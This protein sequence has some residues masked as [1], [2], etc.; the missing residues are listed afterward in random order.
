MTPR[1]VSSN[2]SNGSGLGLIL[3]CCLVST[4]SGQPNHP[5]EIGYPYI[6]NFSS[7]DFNNAPEATWGTIKDERGI[8]Y[9]GNQAGVLEYDGAHWH[10]ITTPKKTYVRTFAKDPRNGR[11]YV[12]SSGDFGYL[13]PD[14]NGQ[15]QFVS[16]LDKVQESNRDFTDIWST[17]WTK[18][19]VYFLAH[20][21]LFRYTDA[22]GKIFAFERPKSRLVFANE[23]RGQVWVHDATVGFERISGDNLVPIP[24]SRRFAD[25]RRVI[26]MP[27]GADKILIADRGPDNPKVKFNSPLTL[28]DG[29]KFEPFPS[30]ADAFL[31]AHR[32]TI[33]QALDDGRFALGTTGVGLVILDHDGRMRWQIGQETGLIDDSV[34]GIYPDG[35]RLW[36]NVSKGLSRVDLP[37]PLS[38]FGPQSGIEGTKESI[39]RYLRS[40]YVGT[41]AGVYR[42]DSGGEG[43]AHFV[44]IPGTENLQ[45]PD[46][47]S[48]SDGVKDRLI[49]G[50][51]SGLFEIAAGKIQP[52][53]FHTGARPFAVT[54][55][56]VSKRDPRR[57]FVGL[58]DGL[59]SVRFDGHG[60]KDEG[61]FVKIPIE[62]V[63][64]IVEEP[65]GR[66]WLSAE[67]NGVQSFDSAKTGTDGVPIRNAPVE[68]Y[69]LKGTGD[70]GD[71]VFDL[72][73]RLLFTS[74][75][76]AHR[77]RLDDANRGFSELTK[78]DPFA[79]ALADP[80]EKAPNLQEDSK[81]DIWTYRG[82]N[83]FLLSK[84]GEQYEFMKQSV[85]A[86]FGSVSAVLREADGV[87]WFGTLK[88]LLRYD[89]KNPRTPASEVRPL[90]RRVIASGA[91]DHRVTLYGGAGEPRDYGVGQLD[92]SYRNVRFEYA[93][94]ISTG[95]SAPEFQTFLEGADDP[96]EWSEETSHDFTNLPYKKLT[97][98]VRVRNGN[99]GSGAEATY[100]FSIAPPFY[101]TWWAYSFYAL[102]LGGTLW[103]AAWALRRRVMLRERERARL[104]TE[105]LEAEAK[106]LNAEKHLL[107]EFSKDNV[108]LDFD[109]IFVKLREH[110]KDLCD[111]PVFRA[112]RYLTDESRL[113]C[114][115]VVE[116]GERRPAFT[117]D[118]TKCNRME[119]WCVE[120][121]KPVLIGDAAEQ[122]GRYI[123]MDSADA[124]LRSR[125]YAPLISQG[126]VRGLV[127][128]GSPRKDAYTDYHFRLV[129]NLS[130][131]TSIALDNADAYRQISEQAADLRRAYDSVESLSEIGRQITASLDLD[132]VLER[133]YQYVSKV[134]DAGV[135]G[136]GILVPDAQR[137]E[138]RLAIS[139][140]E[141]D[142]HAQ[143]DTRDRNQFAVWCIEHRQPVVMN[144]VANEYSRYIEQMDQGLVKV[145]EGNRSLSPASIIYLPLV[146]QDRV[147]GVITVQSFKKDAYTDYQV[148]LLKNLAAYTSIAI[149]N[150]TAYKRLN[151]REQ[152]IQQRAA[153]L[154]TVNE[155]GQA[156]TSK[157]EVH[158]LI[159]LVGDKVRQV[160]NAQITYV[161]LHAKDR[162][163][164]EFPYGYG[165]K[166]SPVP[167]GKGMASRI[168]RLRKPLL[169]NEGASGNN[170]RMGASQTDVGVTS[171]LAVP[172]F[173]GGEIVGVLGVEATD[174]RFADADLRLLVTI[175]AS[176][177]VALHNARLYEEAAQA[178]L[179]AEKADAA[180]SDFL[181]TVSHEL[182]TPLT[183]V[184]GFA[185]IIKRRLSERL[186]PL[187]PE[188]DK[189][190]A[191]T[192]QQ[193][194]D[195]LD[196]VV[197]EGERL[198]KLIDEVLDLAKIEAGKLEWRTESMDAAEIVNRAI[199]ATSSLVENKPVTL[200]AEIAPDLPRLTGDRDRFIQVVINLIS[201]AV[202]FTTQGSVTC[203]AV[204]VKD[205]VIISVTDTG[206]GITLEDQPKVFEKFKQVGDS[207]TDKPKGTGLGLPIC[208]E[209]VEHHGGRIWVE[210]EPGKGS[211][212]SFSIPPKAEPLVLQPLSL[213]SLVKR[214]RESVDSNG[215]G[216]GKRQSILVVDDDPHIREL[217]RQEFQEAGHIV[218]LASDGREAINSVREEKPGLVVLDVMMPE[219]SGF[220]VAAV[221]KNDPATMDIPIIMLSIVED[222]ERGH[223]LGI[224][225]YLTKPV[226]TELLFREVDALMEQGKSKK[227]VM[228]VDEDKSTVR[229]LAEVLQ[230]RGYHV[231]ETKG[232]DLVQE[233]MSV[234]PDVIILNSVFSSKS[235]IMQTL[236]FENGLENVLFLI[237]Q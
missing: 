176:V 22:D 39:I 218:R 150:A 115:L 195:N 217:L 112:G 147:I 189:K 154:A 180:K 111:A 99:G 144:D 15:M 65:S 103:G 185:K 71:M 174:R 124:N 34:Y 158:S 75:D 152:E 234:K 200:T 143:R 165:R 59:A 1:C 222:K 27:Y 26:L 73:D 186:F 48:V 2:R 172:I 35:D 141:R 17:I 91:R 188:G 13:A 57:I 170:Y 62:R 207:L 9:V 45:A 153:E 129:Q 214:L 178:R 206:L 89:S 203:R 159:E 109:T 177:G 149:D 127:A 231:V 102:I 3:C 215:H 219:M 38:Y 119:V 81:G 19:G 167:V 88:G 100:S 128:V 105:A 68:S 32:I 76:F 47:V 169:I 94:P 64:R 175:A 78:A 49:V 74:N 16:L 33:G 110:V 140:G 93:A 220:D 31:I 235:Q 210:S 106:A 21:R 236:R 131:Y 120:H 229:T 155:V 67:T 18:E 85:P 224:D 41:T 171:A 173:A 126:K 80:S 191:Q 116:D 5:S 216:E 107:A 225:R 182:R 20:S 233:A 101:R 133:V 134:A 204:R 199:A 137:I 72:G 205:D 179:A 8:I 136:V 51:S 117:I 10:L 86:D 151:E 223:R 232:D 24:D 90:I 161:A 46:M 97:F 58:E 36:V 237:Y 56:T 108:S 6:R 132:T 69:D 104:K 84:R 202:K 29:S 213:E 79:G 52:I 123:G 208:K 194:G 37:P 162:G 30:G 139:Q 83:L 197:S 66:I 60:W 184:L 98:H 43:G 146:T 82:R 28:Y 135:F 61:N 4:L 145:R 125:I 163:M 160:F 156:A 77:Y 192:I 187:I 221:L 212:F 12:G 50:S 96:S 63:L 228:I 53:I 196:V 7:A 181:S 190:I 118:T 54:T 114:T 42:L 142:E 55:L 130:A 183:S 121:A 11:I 87:T 70:K 193:V 198:T 122:T 44:R 23:V 92:S 113:D 166:F 40:L 95:E 230:I 211:T 209:I 25:S 157:L 148:N 14:K 138:Y 227:K 168:L 164:I 201:N 226:D